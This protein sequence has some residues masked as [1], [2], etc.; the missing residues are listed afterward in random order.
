M[1]IFLLFQFVF[2]IPRRNHKRLF[3]N[4]DNFFSFPFFCLPQ[5]LKELKPR[6]VSSEILIRKF[7]IWGNTPSICRFQRQDPLIFT[8]QLNLYMC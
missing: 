2:L 5:Y 8:I 4:G 3:K 7:P 1:V 6:I